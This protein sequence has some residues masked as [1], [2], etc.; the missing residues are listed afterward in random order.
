MVPE[1]TRAFCDASR[2][3]TEAVA[4]TAEGHTVALPLRTLT[5]RSAFSYIL[6]GLAVAYLLVLHGGSCLEVW[7][8]WQDYPETSHGMLIPIIT[9]Y[10]LVVRRA[11]GD[12]Y[13]S[14]PPRIPACC[15]Q[16]CLPVEVRTSAHSGRL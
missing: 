5:T 4:G 11:T 7:G 1:T 15:S 13:R 12:P 10:L 8:V 14:P 2:S 16:F 9:V 3:L 6:V